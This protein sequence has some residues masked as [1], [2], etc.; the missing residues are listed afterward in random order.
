MPISDATNAT[1][2]LDAFSAAD[3][4]AYTV[5]VSKEILEIARIVERRVKFLPDTVSS[6]LAADVQPEER[7]I[8][9]AWP[10]RDFRERERR[11]CG[12]RR[13]DLPRDVAGC[14]QQDDHPVATGQRD[15]SIS[16]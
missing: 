3:E 2:N 11:Q 14:G 4:G 12:H 9:D 8:V 10:G 1:L 5:V 13:G 7:A 16:T 6:K 15:H